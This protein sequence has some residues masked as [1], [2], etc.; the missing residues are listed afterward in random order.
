ML[1]VPTAMP[2]IASIIAQRLENSS[3]R[4]TC[5]P[6]SSEFAAVRPARTPFPRPTREL[7]VWV[8]D[9]PPPALPPGRPPRLAS[10]PGW[11]KGGLTTGGDVRGGGGH[12]PRTPPPGFPPQFPHPGGRGMGGAAPDG[13]AGR[14]GLPHPHPPFDA[15]PPGTQPNLTQ[16]SPARTPPPAPRPP[17]P[18][19]A[20]PGSAPSP[21]RPP[22]TA[23]PP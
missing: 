3:G 2:S 23:R 4:L 5:H 21:T 9:S 19:P 12:T 1:P 20:C 17:A 8:G 22:A 15:Y 13:A 6:P 7:R 10:P 14:Q 18:A 11:G 16:S